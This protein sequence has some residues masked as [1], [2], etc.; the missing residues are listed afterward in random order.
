MIPVKDFYRNLPVKTCC[1]C[2]APLEEQHESYL[3]ECERCL[4]E[5]EE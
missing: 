5:K 2:G 1:R 4:N 3:N